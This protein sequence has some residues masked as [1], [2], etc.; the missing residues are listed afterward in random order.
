MNQKQMVKQ[1]VDFCQASFNNAYNAN[2]LLQDQFERVAYTMLD[3]ATWIPD[4]G[5]QAIGKWVDSYK[6]GRDNFK[7]HMDNSYKE[8]E[9]FWAE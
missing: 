2:S 4:E 9:A 6:S 3:Q 5:R 7:R 1:M 8:A